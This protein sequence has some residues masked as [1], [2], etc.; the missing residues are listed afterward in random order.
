MQKSILMYM[1]IM[2]ILL[3]YMTVQTSKYIIMIINSVILWWE[4]V[5]DSL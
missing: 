4:G 1:C 2:C 5:S 3:P